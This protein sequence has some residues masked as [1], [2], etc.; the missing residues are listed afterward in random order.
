MRESECLRLC[1]CLCLYVCYTRVL[2]HLPSSHFL[3]DAGGEGEGRKNEGV[4]GGQGKG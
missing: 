1:L 2:L 3:L 4:R